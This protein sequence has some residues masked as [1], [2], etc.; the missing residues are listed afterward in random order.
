MMLQSAS[1]SFVGARPQVVRRG[2]RSAARPGTTRLT[3]KAMLVRP[4]TVRKGD[5]IFK[6]SQKR[7]VKIDDILSVNHGLRKDQIAE[8][9]TILL[10]SSKLSE[11]DREI[12]EGVRG[13]G[14]FRAYPVRKGETIEDIIEKR[15]IKMQEVEALNEDVDLSSLKVHQ[16]IKLP[17]NKFTEREKEMLVGC[18]RVPAAFFSSKGGISFG[19]IGLVILVAGLAGFAAWKSRED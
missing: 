10:P 12:L 4:Y 7:D 2:A 5:T 6:I 16:V 18:A 11:R 9:Q 19:K 1:T 15:G 3:T 13:K 14:K 8:G 17:R